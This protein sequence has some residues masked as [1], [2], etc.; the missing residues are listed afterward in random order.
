MD[1][2]ECAEGVVLCENSESIEPAHEPDDWL[3]SSV[4]ADLNAE[5]ESLFC[6]LLCSPVT[7]GIMA[8]SDKNAQDSENERQRGLFRKSEIRF[9]EV[10]P[11]IMWTEVLFFA[12]VFAEVSLSEATGEPAS[13]PEEETGAIIMKQDV[14]RGV[15]I[16]SAGVRGE[17]PGGM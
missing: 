5:F 14:W 12:S 15:K 8:G 2:A 9:A 10:E 17:C 3:S 16:K 4:V 7:A 6:V 13:R 11:S 1:D